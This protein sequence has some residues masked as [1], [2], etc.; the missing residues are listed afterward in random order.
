MIQITTENA[1]KDTKNVNNGITAK[2]FAVTTV[3]DGNA[4]IYHA[5]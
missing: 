1:R 2:P 5:V 4:E 3:S